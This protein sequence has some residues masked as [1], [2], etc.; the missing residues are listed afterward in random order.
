[1]NWNILAGGGNRVPS[2]VSHIQSHNPELCVLTEYRR[3]DSGDALK[4]A[5]LQHGYDHVVEPASERSKNSVAIFSKAILAPPSNSVNIPESLWPYLVVTELH[6]TCVIGV[7][8][9]LRK[10][11]I[12]LVRFLRDLSLQ[13]PERP[14]IVVGDFFFG[15]R[16]SDSNY[17]KPLRA[18][19]DIGWVSAW[20]AFHPGEEW[21]SCQ[22]SRG[23]SRPDD[24]Y[25]YGPVIPK[26]RQ[27]DTCP[28]PPL[29]RLSDHA[30][31]IAHFDWGPLNDIHNRQALPEAESPVFGPMV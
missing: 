29:E 31:M 27:L 24:F 18:I 8:C 15:P 22:T 7:F 2:I 30:P 21:W 6:G 16:L 17:G 13:Q 26:I 23:K 14:F 12:D 5:L 4:T 10:V 19:S 1:M 20:D 9:A 28:N 11:G 25:L 3:G